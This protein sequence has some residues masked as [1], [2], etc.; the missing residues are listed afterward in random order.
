VLFENKEYLQLRTLTVHRRLSQQFLG[1]KAAR[2]E[3]EKS[4]LRRI[5]GWLFD[6]VSTLWKLYI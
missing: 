6:L 4:F 1:P 5:S 2:F 3:I